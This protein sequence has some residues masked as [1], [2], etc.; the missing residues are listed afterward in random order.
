MFFDL[1]QDLFEK[2]ASVLIAE[3]IVFEAS[4]ASTLLRGSDWRNDPWVD[5]N[6]KCD[7]HVSLMNQ[8]IEDGRGAK[9]TIGSKV[10][11]AVLKNHD[12][13]WGQGIILSG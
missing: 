2:K 7:G 6:A 5:E 11:A 10:V 3:G 4:I 9:L 13:G 1:R 8:I 12:A